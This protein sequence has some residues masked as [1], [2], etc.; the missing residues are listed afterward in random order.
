VNALYVHVK[1]LLLAHHVI[2]NLAR[3]ANLSET[4]GDVIMSRTAITAS[5]NLDGM[6]S[7]LKGI[8]APIGL[9]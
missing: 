2:P 7:H 6:M 9:G 3:F 4:K 8:S 5:V 1:D